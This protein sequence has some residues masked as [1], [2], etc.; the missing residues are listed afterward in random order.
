M[1]NLKK[2]NNFILLQNI[3]P[4]EPA[5]NTWTT[6]EESEAMT[7]H[8]AIS[9]NWFNTFVKHGG[10]NN[11]LEHGK[12]KTHVWA[13]FFNKPNCGSCRVGP[14]FFVRFY[15]HKITIIYALH[16][17][18]ISQ[19]SFVTN[20]DE[21]EDLPIVQ[22]WCIRWGWTPGQQGATGFDPLGIDMGPINDRY[23][24]TMTAGDR[25]QPTM[26]GQWLT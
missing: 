18:T 24:V 1:L 25:G 13:R 10:Q 14:S 17:C 19:L 15:W 3:L 12:H 26:N 9:R 6:I 8:W 11:H 21:R 16:L 4:A 22:L 5:R 2:N 20:I 7:R 23:L